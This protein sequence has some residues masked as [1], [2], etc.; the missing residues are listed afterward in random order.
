MT[1]SK[2]FSVA[3]VVF[4]WLSSPL[5]AGVLVVDPLGAPGFNYMSISSAVNAAVSGDLV[6]VRA[7]GFYGHVF[8]NGKAVSIVVDPGAT[9]SLKTVHVL[10][11]PAGIPVL[12]RGLTIEGGSPDPGALP[13]ASIEIKNCAAPVI[14]EDCV[15]EGGYPGLGVWSSQDVSVVRCKLS[16][17]LTYMV[18][19]GIWLVSGHGME[20]HAST[21]RVLGSEIQGG[22][23]MDAGPLYAAAQGK[24]AI[25]VEGG[26]VFIQGS[27]AV[28]GAGGNGYQSFGICDFPAW[29]GA[30][31][32]LTSFGGKAR[33]LD[34]T[35][36]VGPSGVPAGGCPPTPPG[37]AIVANA[38]FIKFLSGVGNELTT[39]SPHR[40]GETISL[41]VNG[42]PGYLAA[43][44]VSTPTSSPFLEGVSSTLHVGQSFSTVVLGA[45]P[46][47]GSLSLQLV[48]PPAI[49]SLSWL[50]LVNQAMTCDP[51]TSE[52]RLGVPSAVTLLDAGL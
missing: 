46:A 14:V 23:G 31:L 38:G 21:S 12:I 9:V 11:V 2:L 37:P 40:E 5:S 34:S 7:S 3:F 13:G 44:L 29:G 49:P 19:F 6:L 18:G 1:R 28:G 48:V 39:T 45:I 16:G 36:E 15:A 27:T 30:A 50:G 25:R 4:A 51:S 24:A 41:N 52:C 10:D 32:F 20:S 8:I 35:I 17:G 26:E 47:S 33:V 43:V 42:T 22:K